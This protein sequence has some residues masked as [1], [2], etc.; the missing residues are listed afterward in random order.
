MS[1]NALQRVSMRRRVT[2][3]HNLPLRAAAR[4]AIRIA[5]TPA[6]ATAAGRQVQTFGR[7]IL[8]P[9]APVPVVISDDPQTRLAQSESFWQRNPGFMK[10]GPMG[11]IV[12]GVFAHIPVLG[13][14]SDWFRPTRFGDGQAMLDQMLWQIRS[15]RQPSNE[16]WMPMNAHLVAAGLEAEAALRSGRAH[17]LT[18]ADHQAWLGYLR[19]SDHIRALLMGPGAATGY[20]TPGSVD[21]RS[22]HAANMALSDAWRS[23]SLLHRLEV[24]YIWRPVVRRQYWIAHDETIQAGKHA[25]QIILQRHGVQHPREAAL[26]SAWAHTI[27]LMR[28]LN[29]PAVGHSAIPFQLAFLPQLQPLDDIHP[30]VAQ[31]MFVRLIR[32]FDPDQPAR[33]KHLHTPVSTTR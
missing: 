11:D 31:R 23:A 14:M 19:G 29:P 12:R 5:D 27:K 7:P 18:R 13:S 15:G 22:V 8:Q 6:R 2:A 10:T 25:S 3:R 30:T 24:A 28:S 26:G 16:W 9:A 32:M 20:T 4:E 33:K 21:D 1:A 17:E